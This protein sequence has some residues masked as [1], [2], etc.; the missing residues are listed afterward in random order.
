MNTKHIYTISNIGCD[1]QYMYKW[2]DL[3]TIGIKFE[4]VEQDKKRQA[5]GGCLNG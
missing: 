1:V 2:T 4:L 3:Y 5:V